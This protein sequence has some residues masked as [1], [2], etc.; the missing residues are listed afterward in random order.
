M[1]VVKQETKGINGAAMA[2]NTFDNNIVTDELKS[3]VQKSDPYLEKLLLEA[4]C[5]ISDKQLAEGMQDMGAGGLL[6]AT[7]EV[8]KRGREKTNSNMGCTIDLNQSAHQI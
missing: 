5:E 7:L 2:S 3:N 8:I 1:L 6:C 4:C